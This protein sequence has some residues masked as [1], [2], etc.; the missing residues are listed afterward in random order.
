MNQDINLAPSLNPI[1][2]KWRHKL[3]LDNY[4][5]TIKYVKDKTK[6]LAESQGWIIQD[7]QSN[8]AEVFILH[9]DLRE[10]NFK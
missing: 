10:R 2:K 1:L 9:P 3:R 8:T 6:V 5:I 7:E 4:D